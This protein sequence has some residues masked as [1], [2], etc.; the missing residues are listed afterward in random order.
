MFSWCKTRFNHLE[1]V[2]DI[3]IHVY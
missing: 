1:R 3:T 2:L